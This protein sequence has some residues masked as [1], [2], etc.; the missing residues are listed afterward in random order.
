MEKRMP[1]RMNTGRNKTHR[2]GKENL[3]RASNLITPSTPPLK[4]YRNPDCSLTGASASGLRRAALFSL[5]LAAA[6]FSSIQAE[7]QS[8]DQQIFSTTTMTVGCSAGICGYDNP[9]AGNFG[10]LGND[11]F[12]YGGER[13]ILSLSID[14]AGNLAIILKPGQSFTSQMI[15]SLTFHLDGDSFALKDASLDPEKRTATWGSTGLSWSASQMVTVRITYRTDI[16][17]HGDPRVGET[18]SVGTSDQV[19]ALPLPEGTCRWY[20]WNVDDGLSKKNLGDDGDDC[21]YTLT[22]EDVGEYI[23]AEF[24]S[25]SG[26]PEGWSLNT[27]GPVERAGATPPPTGPPPPPESGEDED[28]GEASCPEPPRT[29]AREVR[30]R[31]SLREFVRG[32]KD[33]VR[34]QMEEGELNGGC[35]SEDG[36]WRDG[37][38]YLF[39]ITDDG[40]FLFDAIHNEELKDRR[41]VAVDHKGN[42]VWEKIDEALEGDG[43]AEYY[44][45]DPETED[46]NN[47]N[48]EWLPDGESPGTSRKVSYAEKFSASGGDFIIGSGIYLEAGEEE[49]ESPGDTGGD[50]GGCAVA[51]TGSR[52]ESAAFSLFLTVALL[53]AVS[54]G[55]KVRGL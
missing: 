43:F 22:D 13:E 54:R 23:R 47:K 5:L 21:E 12:D 38:V 45:D 30:D 27:L 36:D 28:E 40:T 31:E 19:V 7:A 51:G 8:S 9:S 39:V 1:I 29:T 50:S 37:S 6:L 34:T 3:P 10:S 26:S 20:H 14:S 33:A 46:D 48:P 15:E 18:L 52:A 49:G 4:K 17:I 16:K 24:S 11:M 32:A 2:C 53:W 42:D 25:E 44:W 35:Y 41:L 55:G